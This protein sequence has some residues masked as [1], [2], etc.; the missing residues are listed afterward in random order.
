ME[1]TSKINIALV[2]NM[3]FKLVVKFYHFFC[4]WL[5]LWE[6]YGGLKCFMH[7][8]TG[9]D[10]FIPHISK[11]MGFMWY[12]LYWLLGTT[13][14]RYY[15][16]SNVLWISH[17]L[18]NTW[19]TVYICIFPICLV[20]TQNTGISVNICIEL[21][22]HTFSIS[23]KI[24]ETFMQCVISKD[25]TKSNSNLGLSWTTQTIQFT[26]STPTSAL[27]WIAQTTQLPKLVCIPST[28]YFF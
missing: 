27:P 12:T 26:I 2:R 6:D 17:I 22:F 21:A 5:G 9:T 8:S 20:N 19:N 24:Y 1:K 13:N 23:W 25:S 14:E 28:D 18:E 4:I 11:G 16:K 15:Y 10:T 3:Q 7:L